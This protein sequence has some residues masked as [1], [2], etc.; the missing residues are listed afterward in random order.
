VCLG[1]REVSE[2]VGPLALAL[3]ILPH[4]TPLGSLIQFKTAQSRKRHLW[5]HFCNSINMAP[6]GR[7]LN[8]KLQEMHMQSTGVSNVFQSSR[9]LL[10]ERH[11]HAIVNAKDDGDWTALHHAS[12]H[13]KLE[14]IQYLIETC[15]ANIQAVNMNGSTPLHSASRFGQLETVKYLVEAAGADACAAN[16][17]GDRHTTA[18]CLLEQRHV[19]S[20]RTIPGGELQCEHPCCECG[21]S[22]IVARCLRQRK[23]GD[24]RLFGGRRPTGCLTTSRYAYAHTY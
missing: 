11:G 19:T 12:I 10:F 14:V 6:T 2:V 13:D 3:P 21:W 1:K 9:S 7:H 5:S 24:G 23:D 22:H 20:R 18:Q 8:K 4:L 16:K 17:E 15:G